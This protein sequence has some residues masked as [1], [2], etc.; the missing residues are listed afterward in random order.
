MTARDIDED[1]LEN[2]ILSVRGGKRR[3][4]VIHAIIAI[5]D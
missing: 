1:F 2:V 4:M 3:S 5:F